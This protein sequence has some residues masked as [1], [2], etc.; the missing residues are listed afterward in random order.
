MEPTLFAQMLKMM[1]TDEVICFACFSV[2]VA[3]FLGLVRLELPCLCCL[4]A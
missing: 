1:Y 3:C 4:A 2:F